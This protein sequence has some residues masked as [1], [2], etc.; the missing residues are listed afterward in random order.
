MAALLIVIFCVQVLDKRRL[1]I[2]ERSKDPDVQCEP[3]GSYKKVQCKGLW[4]WCVDKDG[5]RVSEKQ[6]NIPGEKFNCPDG[7]MNFIII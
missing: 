3:D 1:C 7:K 6:P 4:C 2:S 5:V